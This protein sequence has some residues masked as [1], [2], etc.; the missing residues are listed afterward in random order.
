MKP[1]LLLV[2]ALCRRIVFANTDGAE[3]TQQGDAKT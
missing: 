3:Q 2:I 1:R